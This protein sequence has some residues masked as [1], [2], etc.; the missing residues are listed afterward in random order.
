MVG[1]LVLSWFLILV[2]VLVRGFGTRAA[3][4]KEVRIVDESGLHFDGGWSFWE[5]TGTRT[6]V[7]F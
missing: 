3:I 1:A 2:T 4:D 6:H 7:R 5:F